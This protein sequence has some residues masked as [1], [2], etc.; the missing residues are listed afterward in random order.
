MSKATLKSYLDGW[1]MICSSTD[2]SVAAMVAG[3]HPDIR[4]SDVNSPNVHIGHDGIRT[5]CRLATQGYSG[6]TLAYRD[7]LFD[8][9]NWSIRWTLSGTR[10][11]K[12]FACRGASAG[13]VAE[14]GRVIE[15]TDYWNRAGLLA[16]S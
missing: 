14:D 15:H 10:D 1:A 2:E 3:A 9:C 5:I 13:S 8:G 11:G 4:F 12:P 7:L 16:A 6:A